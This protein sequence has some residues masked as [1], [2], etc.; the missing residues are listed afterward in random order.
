MSTRD[1]KNNIKAH[2]SI[3]PQVVTTGAQSGT[4]I[5]TRDADAAAVIFTFGA[6]VGAGAMTVK[7]Q[8]SDTTTGG[9]F[10]D[11]AAA[12]QEGTVVTPALT[13]TTQVLGYKGSK[14]YI[15]PVATLDSGTSV[16]VCANGI[17]HKLHIAPPV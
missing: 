6:I 4:A 10:T 15:R 2:V 3:A 13:G 14:R 16:A 17:T 7:L 11:V 5:D 1:I 12:D 9:D 8:E